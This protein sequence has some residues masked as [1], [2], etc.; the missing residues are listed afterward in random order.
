MSTART[1]KAKCEPN[2]YPAVVDGNTLYTLEELAR[3]LRWRKHSIRQALRAGLRAPKF[4]SRRYVLGADAIR[5]FQ[6]LAE[7]QQKGDGDPAKEGLP[8]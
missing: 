5:F 4:G 6:R 7:Q 2:P 3:R 1:A 8:E